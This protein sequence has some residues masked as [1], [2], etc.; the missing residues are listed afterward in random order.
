[1]DII[2]KVTDTSDEVFWQRNANLSSPDDRK[3]LE[4]H[5]NG[6]LKLQMIKMKR[7]LIKKLVFTFTNTI[8]Y[9][10]FFNHR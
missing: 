2:Y 5:E 1:M 4:R 6:G 7:K 8:F 9:N 10:Q 3:L